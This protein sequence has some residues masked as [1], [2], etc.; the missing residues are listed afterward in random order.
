MSSFYNLIIS[1]I[2]K[3]SERR[4]DHEIMMVLGWFINLFKKKSTVFGDINSGAYSLL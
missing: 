2:S 1:I 3:P 4:E